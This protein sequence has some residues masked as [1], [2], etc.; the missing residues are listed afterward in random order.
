MLY[1]YFRVW[2]LTGIIFA[3][4]LFLTQPVLAETLV[5][6]NAETR[7][8]VAMRAGQAELQKQVPAPWQ[9]ISIPGGPF[10]DANFFMVFID[11][12]LVQDAQGKPEKG[13]TSRRVVFAVPAKNAQTGEIST[14]VT[15]GFIANP[16]SVPGPYKNFGHAAI[17]SLHTQ[18]GENSGAG[19]GEDS[20]EVRD[21]GEGAIEL[22][23]RRTQAFSVYTA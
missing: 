8:V 14:M 1:R 18:K 4:N 13:G 22:R 3:G 19:T 10:K 21:N 7:I 12:F 2:F 23:I 17:Q 6:S 11:S 15:G 9:V 5:E 20:W 16:E